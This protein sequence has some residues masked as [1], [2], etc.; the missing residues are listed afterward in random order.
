MD[1]TEKTTGRG[2]GNIYTPH[3]GAMIIHVQRE[4]GLANRTIVLSQRK[5]R[6]L[7]R[8]GYVV[9]SFLVIVLLSWFFLAAEAARVPSLTRRIE[10]LQ[11]DVSRLDTL[12]AALTNLEGRF[13]QVQRMLGA[14]APA[15]S[16]LPANDVAADTLPNQWPLGTVGRIVERPDSAAASPGIDIDVPVGTQVRASG[17][18]TVVEVVDDSAGAK[19]IRIAHRDGYE[20]VYGNTRD[21]RVI[22]GQHVTVGTVIG[23]TAGAT[24]TL[25]P[26]LHFEIRHNGSSVDP[27]SLMKQ[28]PANGDLQ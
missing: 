21:V 5:V 25:P 3:A 4:S 24:L 7:R 26:H 11:H 22:K 6:I 18:G 8:A 9:G 13:Q 16:S 12:Q 19:L 1:S 20:T 28:G 2:Y 27:M 14:A 15:S 10:R 23:L 17:T